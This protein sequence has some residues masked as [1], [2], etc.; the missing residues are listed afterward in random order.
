M[1][2]ALE[3]VDRP[4]KSIGLDFFHY[5]ILMDHISGLPM[6]QKIRKTMAR[7]VIDQFKNWFSIFSIT[8]MIRSNNGYYFASG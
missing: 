6:F 2:L 1:R 5:L 3:Y 7:D 4:M 8:E